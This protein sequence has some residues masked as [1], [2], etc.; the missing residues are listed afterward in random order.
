MS[1]EFAENLSQRLGLVHGL[2][3]GHGRDAEQRH[4]ALLDGVDGS[5]SLSSGPIDV[6]CVLDWTW[7]SQLPTHIALDGDLITARQVV[8]SR[9]LVFKRDQVDRKPEGFLSAIISKRIEPPIDVVQHVVNCFRSHRHIAAAAHLSNTEALETFLDVIA[10]E[11][12]GGNKIGE[13]VEG[14][15]LKAQKRLP[16]DHKAHLLEELRFSR[17]AGRRAELDLTMR[18]AAGMVF[19]E[20]HADLL[21]EPLEPQLFG[22][23]PVPDKANRTQLGAY[24]TPPGLA[25]N[26]ADLAIADHLHKPRIK[27]VDPACGSG[28]FL[29][30]VLRALERRSYEGEVEL[31]GLDVSAI[32]VVMAKFALE[33][34]GFS[35][36]PGVSF[37]VEV[38]DFLRRSKS[39]EADVILMNPPFLAMPEME[40][41]VR[42]RLQKILGDA[43]RYRPDLS[44]AFTS[45]AQHHLRRGGTLATLLPAG[46]LSQ[47]GGVKWRDGLLRSNEVELVAVLGEHGLFRDAIVNIAAL[48]LRKQEHTSES[49]ATMLWASQKRGASSS[50]LRR[51]RRWTMGNRNAER[52]IDWSIYPTSQRIL[53]ERDDWTPRPYSLGELPERLSRTPGVAAVENLFQVELGVRAGKVGASLQI[54][55]QDYER[56]PKKEREWFRPVAETRSIRNGRI[57]PISWIFYPDEVMTSA[58]IQDVAPSFHARHLSQLGLEADAPVDLERA[59]RNTNLSLRPR[60]VARA[61]IGPESFAVDENGDLVVVQGYSW[62]PKEPI[63]GAPF[64]TIELLHDYAFLLNSRLFF[65]LLRENGR[66]VGG[67]QVDGAKNQVRRVPLP[68]LGAMYLETPELFDEARELRELDQSERPSAHLLDAFAAAAYRTSLEEWSLS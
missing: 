34:G 20:A 29:C 1:L 43:F 35:G 60:I 17:L 31:V 2:L 53:A 46:A 57:Q 48:V 61:F 54:D 24:Y 18:H 21:T 16:F 27:I 52:T 30:E 59:R 11:I 38:A 22:L 68:D 41:D 12:R 36:R 49:P 64:D 39:L 25:R 9:P 51:L 32:A 66:I 26:L 15:V 13:V 62:I 37:T 45:L 44:M 5:F 23:A 40:A 55:I 8:D 14:S 65:A 10:Q 4:H 7:S 67:G 28:I 58:Q 42:E 6:D 19:Q 33:Y 50:A 3:L 47:T 56:L 63:L